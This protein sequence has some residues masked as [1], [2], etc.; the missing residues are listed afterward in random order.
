MSAELYR[1][2]N[3]RSALWMWLC[4]IIHEGADDEAPDKFATI[5]S[6]IAARF[7]DYERRAL[8]R[9]KTRSGTWMLRAP[10]L[11]GRRHRQG[12]GVGTF[13]R[14]VLIINSTTEGAHP[15]FW[16][17]EPKMFK[18]YRRVVVQI[19][20]AGWVEYRDFWGTSPR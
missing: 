20:F 15:A 9:R 6:D 8:S 14:R 16:Q 4:C 1:G 7:N 2:A 11:P 10:H 5:L 18:D 19:S 12:L 13:K 3:L 17:N